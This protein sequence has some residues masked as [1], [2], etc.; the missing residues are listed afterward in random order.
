MKTQRKN[1]TE[2]IE[3]MKSLFTEER[4]YG[5]LVEQTA[6]F[7][8]TTKDQR[9]NV[10]DANKNRKSS[11]S[12]ER[13]KKRVERQQN[14]ETEATK[15]KQEVQNLTNCRKG[16]NNLIKNFLPQNIKKR[17]TV[18]Q[19][20]QNLGGQQAY[21]NV[22]KQFNDCIANEKV[23]NS[24]TYKFNEKPAVEV[25]DSIINGGDET[26]L[27]VHVGVVPDNVL[28]KGKKVVD[29]VKKVVQGD[30]ANGI[31][32]KSGAGK[33]I[34]KMVDQGNNKYKVVGDK[35]RYFLI[36]GTEEID[37]MYKNYILTTLKKPN[38]TITVTP[39]SGKREKDR[40]SFEFT[41]S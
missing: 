25:L 31:N 9:K 1:I 6:G 34:G 38:A 8:Q 11:Q 21:E 40:D 14:R 39:N 16:I 15:K 37:N 22:K 33:T 23:K 2:E 7:G 27:T 12:T 19:Y 20:T 3:R 35:N 17:S 13:K 29:K 30:F 18:A 26:Y 32:I 10:K 4:L 36:K 28:N 24:I 41:V 5:N